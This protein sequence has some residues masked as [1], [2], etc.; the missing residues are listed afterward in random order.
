MARNVIRNSVTNIGTVNESWNNLNSV[1]LR[2]GTN[3]AINETQKPLRLRILYD[4][5][6]EQKIIR[7]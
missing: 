5:V 6:D 4:F 7:C 3:G 2:N 1:V